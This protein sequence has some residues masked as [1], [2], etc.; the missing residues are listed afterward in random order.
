MIFCKIELSDKKVSSF[1]II[2]VLI[3]YFNNLKDIKKQFILNL[4]LF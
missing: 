4:G 1:D 2:K 3:K